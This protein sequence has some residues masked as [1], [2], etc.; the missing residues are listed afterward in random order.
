MLEVDLSRYAE[1]VARADLLE[2]A[3]QL[4]ISLK[5]AGHDLGERKEITLSVRPLDSATAV[6]GPDVWYTDNGDPLVILRFANGALTTLYVVMLAYGAQP[7]D[8]LAAPSA[9]IDTLAAWVARTSSSDAN[10]ARAHGTLLE[11]AATPCATTAAKRLNVRLAGGLEHVLRL[12]LAPLIGDYEGRGVLPVATLLTRPAGVSA[13]PAALDRELLG[14][15]SALAAADLSPADLAHDF[16][17]ALLLEL[18][19]KPTNT[20]LRLVAGVIS[21][22]VHALGATAI[23]FNQATMYVQNLWRDTRN[24]ASTTAAGFKANFAWE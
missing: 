15:L 14:A 9:A 19:G 2:Q 21:H 4:D 7:A 1:R 11:L 12:K 16:H 8:V 5:V 6:G 22:L 23:D 3:H 13:T 20:R 10:M 17:S 24:P 18:K